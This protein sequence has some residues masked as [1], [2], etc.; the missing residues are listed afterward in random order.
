MT[1]EYIVAMRTGVAWE[2]PIKSR[3]SN[4]NLSK[5]VKEAINSSSASTLV[6]ETVISS[7]A[8]T[9]VD[10]INDLGGG[11]EEDLS[12]HTR[13]SSNRSEEEIESISGL[14]IMSTISSGAKSD[15]VPIGMVPIL[16]P[17]QLE[18][19]RLAL[20]KK[21]DRLISN[22]SFEGGE[23]GFICCHCPGSI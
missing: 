10:E 23:F 5:S 2:S 9:L 13:N 3:P 16:I 22:A 7:S 4:S 21:R 17:P 1:D 6:K 8:S 20:E 18:K 12:V 14:S 11:T 19:L 15:R